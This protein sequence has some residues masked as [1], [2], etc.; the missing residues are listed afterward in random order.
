[1]FLTKIHHFN[2]DCENNICLTYSSSKQD[3]SKFSH[4]LSLF[5]MRKAALPW[6]KDNPQPPPPTGSQH[7]M[8]LTF[9]LLM[10]IAI[11]DQT[12]KLPDSR[13]LPCSPVA[14]AW[15]CGAHALSGLWTAMS[16]VP[17]TEHSWPGYT[18]DAPP[19]SV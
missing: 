7:A 4:S 14:S 9:R 3:A 17:V 13:S 11:D 19:V 18:R 12:R 15:L 5:L 2:L 16:D 8:V 10:G 6:Y 1:M